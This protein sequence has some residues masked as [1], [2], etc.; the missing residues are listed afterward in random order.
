MPQQPEMGWMPDD[1]GPTICEG[2]ELVRNGN[3]E[4]GFYRSPYGV[5]GNEWQ[6]FT[7]GGQINYGFYDEQWEAVVAFDDGAALG[8]RWEEGH[9]NGQNGQLIEISLEARLPD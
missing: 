7:N 9:G 6:P 5:V 1:N 4:W 2:P 8:S 3:F